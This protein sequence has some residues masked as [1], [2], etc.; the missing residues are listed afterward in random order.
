MEAE[1][2]IV[3]G[4][5]VIGSRGDGWWRDRKGAMRN[6]VAKLEAYAE[7]TGAKITVV[8]DANPFDLPTEDE[9]NV[10]VVFAAPPVRDA[11]DD[12]IVRM[13]ERDEAARSS[14]VVT[15]DAGLIERVEE[16][17]A[18]VLKAGRFREQ[19]DTLSGHE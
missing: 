15:S 2:L 5:N 18:E 17:G 19:L 3:D 8:F 9:A 11:A 14:R 10:R 4:M 16:L 13:L 7:A 1:R 6:L 12:E